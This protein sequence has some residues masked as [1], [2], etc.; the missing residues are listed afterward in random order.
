MG[1]FGEVAGNSG[2]KLPAGA[3]V[4]QGL[5]GVCLS[6]TSWSNEWKPR[7]RTF[8]RP[9]V[10]CRITGMRG[11][12]YVRN[13]RRLKRHV[14][15][16]MGGD[17]GGGVSTRRSV[18]KGIAT[19]ATSGRGVQAGRDARLDGWDFGLL[20]LARYVVNCIPGMNPG[21]PRRKYRRT[22]PSALDTTRTPRDATSTPRAFAQRALGMLGGQS[23]AHIWRHVPDHTYGEYKKRFRC[24]GSRGGSR[25]R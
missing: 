13:F 8:E 24:K 12:R 19:R 21:Q 18:H 10:V 4:A 11:R 15:G 16:A 17:E 6:L 20:R 25:V 1:D 5:R 3:S 2:A 7:K 14:C 23:C 9:L 22:S